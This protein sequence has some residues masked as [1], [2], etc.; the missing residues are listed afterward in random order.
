MAIRCSRTGPTW[1]WTA[2][3]T[4]SLVSQ[5]IFASTRPGTF[6]ITNYSNL[7]DAGATLVVDGSIVS[8]VTV[9]GTL[10]GIT[11]PASN[12]FTS[13]LGQQFSVI[14]AERRAVLDGAALA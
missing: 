6:K 13:S 11:P 8:P 5:P 9:N 12:D 7:V 2:G 1:R 3:T 14:A 4:W 10:R